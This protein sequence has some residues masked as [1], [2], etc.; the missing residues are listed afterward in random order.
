MTCWEWVAAIGAG[1]A[2][3]TAL[4]FAIFWFMVSKG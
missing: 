1:L 2:T 3:L 4:G